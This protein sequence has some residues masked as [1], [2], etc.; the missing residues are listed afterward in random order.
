MLGKTFAVL[1]AF[2]LYS[3]TASALDAARDAKLAHDVTWGNL[4]G[5]SKMFLDASRQINILI[6]NPTRKNTEDAIEITTQ[7]S[8]LSIDA[9]ANI[10]K[11]C[12]T[13]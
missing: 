7:E 9:L 4:C 5:D 3:N 10:N 13:R 6:M 1:T 8:A 12:A 2:L 11:F